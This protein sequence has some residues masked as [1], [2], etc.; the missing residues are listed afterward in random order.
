[1]LLTTPFYPM[2]L[3]SNL[4]DVVMRSVRWSVMWSCIC[5]IFAIVTGAC[6][7]AQAQTITSMNIIISTKMAEQL[8]GTPG[9]ALGILLF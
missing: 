8:K 9:E 3:A 4:G 7:C 5:I 6:Y 2:I 1:M